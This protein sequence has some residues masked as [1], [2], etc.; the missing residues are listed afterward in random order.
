MN[1][2]RDI[3]VLRID[4]SEELMPVEAR[5]A[6]F[7]PEEGDE[8]A[9]CGYPLGNRLHS[10]LQRGALIVPSFSGGIVS[11]ILPYSGVEMRRLEAI[12]VSAMIN[13][14]NSGGPLFDVST[15]QVVGVVVSTTLNAVPGQSSVGPTGIVR[16]VPVGLIPPLV[17]RLRP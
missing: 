13:P 1:E 11:A 16:A 6:A 15:G 2:P 17:A 3:A 14:G 12:Q 10:D 4:P 7:P 9:V 5:L 8:V